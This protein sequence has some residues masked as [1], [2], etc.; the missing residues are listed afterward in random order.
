MKINQVYFSASGMT[1]KITKR[2]ASRLSNDINIYDLI[3]NP[4]IEEINFDRDDL[5]VVGMPVFAGRIPDVALPMLEN[6]KANNTRAIAVVTYGNRDYDDA[7]LELTN[8]LKKNGFTVISGGA[9][10]AKHSIFQKVATNRPDDKDLKDIDDFIDNT[11]KIIKTNNINSVIDINGNYPYKEA[12]NIP[13]KPKGDRRCIECGICAE[14]CPTNAI[15]KSD[16]R[17]TDKDLCISCT[18]C[19]YAC[20]EKARDFKGLVHWI[21]ERRFKKDNSKRKANKVFYIK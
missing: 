13:L 14:I 17:K 1:E 16:F 15:S 4:I 8:I 6:L 10:V 5:V 3:K 18:A 2:I 21:G 12:G 19:Q 11:N 9:F 20:P 7:L